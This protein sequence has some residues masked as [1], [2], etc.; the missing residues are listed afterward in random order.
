MRVYNPEHAE[1]TLMTHLVSK[2]WMALL[3]VCAASAHAQD[4]SRSAEPSDRARAAYVLGAS[5]ERWSGG[6]IQWYYNPAQQPSNLTTSDVL[7]AINTAVARW[8]GMC[9]LTFTYMGLTS[10]TPNVRSTWETIDRLSVFGWGQLTN[11]L[12]QYGAY[13][14]WWYSSGLMVDAD[15]VINTAYNW[16]ARDVESIMTHELGH[17][18]GLNHSNVQASVM[19][20]SPYNSYSYQRTLR[21]DDASACAALYGAAST[22][23]SNRAMNWA[24]QNYPQYFATSPA[25]SAT[26]SGYYY[27]YYGTTGNYLGT[28]DGNAYMMGADNVIQYLGVLDTFMPTVRAAGF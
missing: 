12:A 25:A 18:L 11:E 4:F 15:V 23:N 5:Q 14:K 21:G 20:A 10:A 19:F 26:Y 1:K 24:E 17:V 28:K 16:T 7:S 13:T 22:A 2:S 6:A 9:N 3:A 8:S 27:R